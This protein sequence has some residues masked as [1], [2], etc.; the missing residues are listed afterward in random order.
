MS[1]SAAILASVFYDKGKDNPGIKA[2]SP[3][4]MLYGLSY[5]YP[6]PYHTG[7]RF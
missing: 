2:N 1:K 4:N 7:M 5:L 3:Y 6:L